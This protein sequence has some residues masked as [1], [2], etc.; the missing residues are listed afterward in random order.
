MKLLPASVHRIVALVDVFESEL[1]SNL[2]GK[3]DSICVSN[4]R[5]PTL[6]SVVGFRF[7]RMSMINFLALSSFSFSFARWYFSF[8]EN[9]S[10]CLTILLS[11]QWKMM[12]YR[13]LDE[14]QSMALI[15]SGH[16]QRSNNHQLCVFLQYVQCSMCSP[17]KVNTFQCERQ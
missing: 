8:S 1:L 2:H 9:S 11:L 5:T 12:Q 16:H 7:F 14:H 15:V 4:V 3:V 13:E 6:E 17:D 10:S